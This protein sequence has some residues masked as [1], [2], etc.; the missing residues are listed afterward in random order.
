MFLKRVFEMP[1][2]DLEDG[3]SPTKGSHPLC[4]FFPQNGANITVTRPNRMSPARIEAR[5]RR[6][7]AI[8]EAAHMVMARHVGVSGVE[9]WIVRTP[10]AGP[11]EK[12]WIGQMQFYPSKRIAL[13]DRIMIGVAGMAA[14]MLID[15][16]TIEISRTTISEI[17][18]DPNAMSQS[19]WR[20]AGLTFDGLLTTSEVRAVTDTFRLLRDKLW[21][22]LL[23]ESRQLVLAC[24]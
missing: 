7:A 5:D 16:P 18:S 12:T 4:D 1:K 24:R 22:E 3:Q 10:N 15:D 14:T 23:A 8:H 9:A 13:R 20:L 19:D 17:L 11:D 2:L 21:Q 6:L